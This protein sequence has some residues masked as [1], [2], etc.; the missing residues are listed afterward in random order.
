MSTKTAAVL[1]MA[2]SLAGAAASGQD[3][4]VKGTSV[5]STATIQAIDSTPRTITLR[6]QRYRGHVQCWSGGATL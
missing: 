1:T 6:D 5:S 4:I 3:P 2:L